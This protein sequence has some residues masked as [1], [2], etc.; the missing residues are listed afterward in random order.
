VAAPQF[1]KRD[2]VYYG[3]FFSGAILAA[4]V[5]TL[6]GFQRGSWVF[7]LGSIGGGVGGGILA[8]LIFGPPKE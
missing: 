8:G 2:L 1:S 5:L 4:G 6:F 7:M 3:G